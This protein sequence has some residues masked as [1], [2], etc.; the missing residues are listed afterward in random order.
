MN[1]YFSIE[2]ISPDDFVPYWQEA[3]S[4]KDKG[5]YYQGTIKGVPV[6]IIYKFQDQ[7]SYPDSMFIF[8]SDSFSVHEFEIEK[9]TELDDANTKWANDEADCL[10]LSIT[11]LSNLDEARK[12]IVEKWIEKDPASVKD[13]DAKIEEL[14]T[15]VIF[16]FYKGLSTDD[17]AVDNT[18]I[19]VFHINGSATE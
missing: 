11:N 17:I 18:K 10:T 12:K 8:K 5:P 13:K 7:K 19:K 14:K 9:D 15:N 2:T 4:R 16:K 1:G 3:D 6:F